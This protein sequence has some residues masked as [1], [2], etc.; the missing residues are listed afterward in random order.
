MD[1]GR[2]KLGSLLGF[3]DEYKCSAC[4]LELQDTSMGNLLLYAQRLI[5]F[6]VNRVMV[7]ECIASQ[8][9]ASSACN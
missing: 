1:A 4:C 2:R 8:T 6:L 5:Y 3:K 9:L 7:Q